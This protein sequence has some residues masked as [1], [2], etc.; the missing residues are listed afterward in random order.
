MKMDITLILIL[1]I[2]LFVITYFAVRLAIS[3]LLNKNEHLKSYKQDSGDLVKLRDIGVLNPDEIEETIKI[4]SNIRIKKENHEQYE[5]YDRILIELK[6]AGYF[7]EEEYG[8]R[9]D[10]LK[11]HYKII[12]L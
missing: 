4:Y 1:A 9:L 10:K 5:K 6:E 12:N 2:F 3:P 11:K 7:S 8:I